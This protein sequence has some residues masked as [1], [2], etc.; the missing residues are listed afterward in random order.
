MDNSAATTDSSSNTY[1]CD[2]T[3]DKV[4]LLSY[5]D[6]MNTSYFADSAARQ[7]KTT[8]W[9][10]ANGV[11]VSTDSSYL[12]NGRYWT[13]SPYSSYSDYAW[14]VYYDGVLSDYCFVYDSGGAV[15]PSLRIKVAQ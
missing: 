1:A 6:Y 12:Y 9:A 8:D 15:R 13:R 7:C 5:Q 2:D 4:Y 14:Y 3:Q 10:R 11:L